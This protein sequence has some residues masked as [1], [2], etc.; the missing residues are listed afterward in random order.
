VADVT[1]GSREWLVSEILRY[2]GQAEVVEPAVVRT[3]VRRS[4]ERLLGELS[5]VALR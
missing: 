2:R 3:Q 1:Y 5:P 4:A